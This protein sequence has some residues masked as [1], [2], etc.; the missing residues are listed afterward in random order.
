MCGRFTQYFTWAELVELYGLTEPPLNLEPRYNIAPTTQVLTVR[1]ERGKHFVSPMRWGLIP[2]YWKSGDK[3]IPMHNARADG[4]A[5]KPSFRAAFKTRR[6]VVP[7]SGFYEWKTEGDPKK[8]VKRPHYITMAD[9]GLMSFAGI[10]EVRPGD[11]GEDL[12]SCSIVTTEPNE[13]MAAVHDRVPVILGRYDI[14]AWI[15]GDDPAA[16]MRPCPAGTIKIAEVST[17][18]SNSRNQGEACIAPL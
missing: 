7:A 4:I 15:S 16:L 5:T 3:L 14:D 2:P 9:G 8:P 18:V 13:A 6:C 12:L 10:W 11:D 1:G 17:F